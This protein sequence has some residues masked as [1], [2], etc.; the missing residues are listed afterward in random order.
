MQSEEIINKIPNEERPTLSDEALHAQA[1]Q[2]IDEFKQL[3][4]QSLPSVI[5]QIIEREVWKKEIIPIKILA[6][7]PLRN[8]QMAWVLLTTKCCGYCGRLWM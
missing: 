8:H 6:N 1:N 7:M 4:F 2:Y 3:I 5:S